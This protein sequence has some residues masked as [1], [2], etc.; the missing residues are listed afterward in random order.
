MPDYSVDRRRYPLGSNGAGQIE[1]T[2]QGCL[3]IFDVG[4]ERAKSPRFQC[5]CHPCWLQHLDLT[6]T[7]TRLGDVA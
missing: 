6:G 4:V 1:L 3:T 5:Y 2:C 7:I